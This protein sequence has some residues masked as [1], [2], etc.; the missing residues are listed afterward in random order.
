MAR[1]PA[2]PPDERDPV[3]ALLDRAGDAF[4]DGDAGEA[5]A[6]ADE[7]LA[8]APRSVPALHFR[9]AAL[10]ELGRTDDAFDAYERAL[11]IGKDDPE[12]LFGAAEF[13]VN[14]AEEGEPDRDLVERGLE[15]ARRGGKLARKRGDGALAADLAW[16]EAVALNQLGRSDEA[17]A[18]L[19][20]A[21]KEAPDSVDVWLE[22][23][24]ALY[25][26][27]RF[28]DAREALL[29]A[30]KLDPEEPWT[31]HQLG[32][33]AERQGKHD[34]AKRRFDRARKLSPDEFPKP[35]ALSSE[36]FDSAVEDAL[37]SLPD[38]VRRYLSN[39]AITV[40]DVP[41]DDDL[42]A[43]DPPLSPAILG[44]FRGA[45]YG[46]KASMDPWSHFPSSIVLYQRNL[47]RFAKSRKD[48]IE[49]IGVTLLHEV[50]H[51]LGLDE[52]ELYARGLD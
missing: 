1:R 7:A 16:V 50:G 33:V 49:Q 32:L 40:E 28:D 45:P 29:R 38:P 43:S 12:L 14:V 31:Q 18:R 19:A 11:A 36:A 39:V 8:A 6:L 48:L 24:F 51:F 47:E 35:I 37:K 2:G 3:A 26:L 25:E 42:L 20:D 27:C 4:E 21:E 5:L 52:D 34:E 9:A 23:G 13:L 44:L 30:E 10:A 15:L 46:Q 41:T 22:K 17:L